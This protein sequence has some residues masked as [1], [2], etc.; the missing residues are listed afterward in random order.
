M[1][2]PRPIVDRLKFSHAQFR[3]GILETAFHKIPLRL[4]LD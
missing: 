2:L 3:F 1:M 4:A